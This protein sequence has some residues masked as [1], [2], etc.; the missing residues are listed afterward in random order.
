MDS[1]ISIYGTVAVSS[2][3]KKYCTD[4]FPKMWV[5]SWPA[6]QLL[7]FKEGLC[8]TELISDQSALI[9]CFYVMSENNYHASRNLSG[10]GGRGR[11]QMNIKTKAKI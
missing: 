4:G 7:A 5:I 9:T 8:S 11:Q 10:T 2:R 6:Q 1:T 3:K